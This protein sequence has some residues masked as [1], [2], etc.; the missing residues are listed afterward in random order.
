[1]TGPELQAEWSAA[2]SDLSRYDSIRYD[3]IEL[4]RDDLS[5]LIDETI[6]I[7]RIDIEMKPC[8]SLLS[9]V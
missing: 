3:Q 2:A 6:M 5:N 7:A 4:E 8:N 9:Y 1:M